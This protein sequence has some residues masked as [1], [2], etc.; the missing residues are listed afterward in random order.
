MKII[1][2]ISLAF[3][4]CLLLSCNNQNKY[5]SS[6]TI[7]RNDF[8]VQPLTGIILDFDSLIMNPN[9]LIVHDTLLI[10]CNQSTSKLFHIFNLKTKKKIGEAV[11]MG[12]GPKEM[13]QPHFIQDNDLISIYDMMTATISQYTIDEFIANPTPNPIRQIKLNEHIF[14]KMAF[15][16]DSTIGSPYNPQHPFFLFN[17]KGEKIKG[18]ASYPVS[19]LTYSDTEIVEAYRADITTN[20][21]DKIAICY[22][23]TD[24]IEIYNKEGKLEKRIHG[25]ER[26]FPHF[27]EY[28]DGVVITAKPVK[29]KYRSAFFSPVSVNDD[30]FVLYDGRNI[31]KDFDMLA[32]QIFVFDWNGKPKQILSLDQGVSYITVDSKNKK[33]YGVSNKPEYR[34]IEYSY[35]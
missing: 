9:Q 35:N 8:P 25:P 4:L 20:Q 15:L 34:I 3:V 7:T 2:Y 32:K 26:F 6:I 11:E 22:Y 29:D 10:T 14:S 24:L 27:K 13:I 23:F 12:Q 5:E 31:D 17:E 19:D 1:I 30:F 18:F 21:K 33:I 16:G 28:T